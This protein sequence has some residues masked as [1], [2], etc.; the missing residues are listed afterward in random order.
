MEPHGGARAVAEREPA[1]RLRPDAMSEWFAARPSGTED[2]YEIYAET[3]GGEDHL[4]RI[5][6]EAQA[7]VDGSLGV[8]RNNAEGGSLVE[9]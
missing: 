9:H 3:F 2:I 4:E 6:G 5:V 7:M 1:G 8:K